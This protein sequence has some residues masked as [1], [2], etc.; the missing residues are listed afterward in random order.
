MVPGATA[1]R[2]AS[3]TLAPSS[4]VLKFETSGCTAD[5]PIYLVGPAQAA[6]LIPKVRL[7]AKYSANSASSR[8]YILNIGRRGSGFRS[9]TP[10][11]RWRAHAATPDSLHAAT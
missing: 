11:K 4:A 3:S 1:G 5:W 7:A 8:P 2:N 9:S 6:S 10:L